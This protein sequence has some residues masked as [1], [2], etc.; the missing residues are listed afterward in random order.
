MAGFGFNMNGLLRLQAIL[1]TKSPELMR[2]CYERWGTRY[3]GAMH[4]KYVTNAAG[5]GDWPRLKTSTVYGRML[6]AKRLGYAR[7]RGMTG[8]MSILIDTKT[9][10]GGLNIGAPGN[11]FQPHSK[12]IRVGYGGP[13]KH[14]NGN[15]TIADIASFHNS[16]VP[17]KLPKRQ[18]IWPPDANVRSYMLRSLQSHIRTLMAG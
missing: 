15:A 1:G 5:G 7:K 12:G 2:P 8:E 6:K 10:L 13:A 9:L 14:P 17:G 18:I 4:R 11:L 16:G 3:L